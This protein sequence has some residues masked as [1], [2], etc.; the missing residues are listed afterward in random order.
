M[1]LS[2]KIIA[3]IILTVFV[4]TNS[5]YTNILAAEKQ[6]GIGGPHI[7]EKDSR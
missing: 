1:K 5:N 6:Y 7:E 4:L 2:R 3:A